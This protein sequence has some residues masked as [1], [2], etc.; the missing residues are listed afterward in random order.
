MCRGTSAIPIASSISAGVQ[1][2]T[3]PEGKNTKLA[4]IDSM[5]AA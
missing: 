2:T 5:K 4:S 1:M 3:V